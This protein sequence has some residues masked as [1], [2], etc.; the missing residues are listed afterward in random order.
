MLLM[1]IF[2]PIHSFSMKIMTKTIAALVHNF[3][4]GFWTE[5][6]RDGWERGYLKL[7]PSSKMR[8]LVVSVR[9]IG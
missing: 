1:L 8:G 2:S 9:S 7:F 5:D 3:D 6:E 4:I